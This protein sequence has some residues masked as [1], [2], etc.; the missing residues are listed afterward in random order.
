MRCDILL[1]QWRWGAFCEFG[2]HQYFCI[3][4]KDNS[5]THGLLRQISVG[6]PD[7][8]TFLG[9]FLDGGSQIGKILPLLTESC[10]TNDKAASS[11]ALP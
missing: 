8:S 1:T 5:P 9:S 10:S 7:P 6:G 3:D 11:S 2:A 4:I